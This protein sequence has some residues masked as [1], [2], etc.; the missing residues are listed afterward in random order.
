MLK[1]VTKH[2]LLG[3]FTHN[4]LTFTVFAQCNKDQLSV[5]K[6]KN[7]HCP[8]NKFPFPPNSLCPLLTMHLMFHSLWPVI[9]PASWQH[10]ESQTQSSPLLH[11]R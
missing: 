5:T 7:R 4:T 6:S 8:E 11:L 10:A 1:S 3:R 2:C 9:V